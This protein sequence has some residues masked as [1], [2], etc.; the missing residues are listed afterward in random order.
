MDA[1]HFSNSYSFVHVRLCV[2]LSHVSDELEHLVGVADLIV[3]PRD[4][5]HES[6][7]EI[8][9]GVGVEDGSESASEEVRRNDSVFC[10]S[11]NTLQFTFSSLLHSGADVSLSSWLSEIGCEVHH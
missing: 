3:V 6:V 11:E 9:S 1:P 8:D 4:N 5:L 7:S 2:N 10:V